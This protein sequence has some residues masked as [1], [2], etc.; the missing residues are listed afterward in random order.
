MAASA[1]IQGRMIVELLLGNTPIPR[2]RAEARG[3]TRRENSEHSKT[4]PRTTCGVPHGLL[5]EVLGHSMAAAALT[6][7][8]MI[9][10]LLLGNTP[11]P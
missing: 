8:R 6:E 4:A 3:V 11:D 9:V 10:A 1:L 7:G 2:T 5:P